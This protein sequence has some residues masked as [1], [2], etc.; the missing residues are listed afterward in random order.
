LIEKA[1]QQFI[2]E[3]ARGCFLKGEHVHV[4][5]VSRGGIDIVQSLLMSML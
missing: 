3:I 2:A 5:A 4:V 1:F